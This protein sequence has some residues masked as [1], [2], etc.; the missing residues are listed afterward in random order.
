MITL[1]R[2]IEEDIGEIIHD[3]KCPRDFTCY[4]SNFKKVRRVKDVGLDSFVACLAPEATECKF[5]I[6]FGGLIFC[7][8]PLRVYIAKNLR[9]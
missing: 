3:L 2:K 8:C 7:Q 1:K 4:S 6:Q 9:K 5:S